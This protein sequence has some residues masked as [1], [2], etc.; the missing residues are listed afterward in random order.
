VTK[1]DQKVSAFVSGDSTLW[2]LSY[3]LSKVEAK[4]FVPRDIMG[5]RDERSQ[6]CNRL[7]VKRVVGFVVFRKGDT[8]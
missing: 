1:I 4:K 3:P 2:L 6:W 5:T 7:L 8:L